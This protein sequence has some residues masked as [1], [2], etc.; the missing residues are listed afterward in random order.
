MKSKDANGACRPGAAAR[1]ESRGGS[2]AGRFLPGGKPRRRTDDE[3]THPLLGDQ[4]TLQLLTPRDEVGTSLV[5]P[6]DPLSL[7]LK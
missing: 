5:Q 3:L 2:M 4:P 6:A 1:L 7:A